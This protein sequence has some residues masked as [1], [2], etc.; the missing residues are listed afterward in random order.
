MSINLSIHSLSEYR[1]AIFY[2]TE[3]QKEIAERVTKEAQ[4]AHFSNDRPIVTKIVAAGPWW[5]AEAYHQ[6]YLIENPHG[7]EC[8]THREHWQM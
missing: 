7:Y 6:K 4:T 1:S 5:D 8:P 2:N 3:E